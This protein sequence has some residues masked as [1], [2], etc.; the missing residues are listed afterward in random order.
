MTTIINPPTT[1]PQQMTTIIN[2]PTTLPQQMT[3][4]INA[5]T[6]IPQQMTTIINIPTTIPQ[7]M[8]TI[9]NAPTTI[10]QQMTT[11]INIPTTIPQKMTTIINAPTTIPQQMTT[12]INAPTTIPIVNIPTTIPQQMTTIIN[13]PTTIPKQM[14]TIVN[15]PTTIPQPQQMTTYIYTPTTI[16]KQMTTIINIPT[17]I[18]KNIQTTIPET[19]IINVPPTTKP[20]TPT[21]SKPTTTAPTTI[22]PPVKEPTTIPLNIMTIVPQQTNYNICTYNVYLN[23]NC[24]FDN[25]DNFGILSKLKD[26]MLRTYPYNG[27]NVE[28]NAL[29][30]YAFQITNSLNQLVS[31]D[32]DFSNIDLGDCERVL[33]EAYG[34][35]PSMS[36][37]FFK[38]ENIASSGVDRDIQYEVY[39]PITYEKLNLSICE[40]TK[41]KITIPLEISEDVLALI[42]NVLDQGYNPFDLNDRFYRE[43]CTPY[44]SENG[45][46]VLLDARE[47]YVYST[48]AEE[49]T[50]PSGCEMSS[51]SL[52]S[53]YITC[54]CN[55]DDELVALDLNHV[56]AAN[57]MNSFLSTL[58]HSNYKVMI[59]YNLVFNFKIFCHN[60]GS[61]LTLILFVIYVLFMICYCCKE[62]NPIKVSISKLLFEEQKKDSDN[63]IK[64]YIFL[65]KSE[66]SKRGDKSTKSKKK[67]QAKSTKDYNPPKKTK[68][69]R[70]HNA[71]KNLHDLSFEKKKGD[72]KLVDIMKKKR[73]SIKNRPQKDEES[74]KS[75]KVRKRKSIVDYQAEAEMVLKTR[76]NLLQ[77]QQ[78]QGR[79]TDNYNDIMQS[80]KSLNPKSEK[81]KKN[82]K[83]EEEDE[84][85]KEF[86]NFEL[87]N[88]SYDEAS[89]HDRRTCLR[90]YL[91]VLLREHYVLF[92][93]CSRNDYN[94]FYVKIERFFIIVCTEMTMNGMFF[95]HETMYKKKTGQSLTLGQKIPQFVFTLIA[96]HF[97]EVILCWLGMTDIYYYE[98]K[99]LPKIQKNDERIFKILDKMKRRLT[100]FYIFTFFVF[101]FHW[102]FISAFCAVY[103]NTQVIFLRD[104]GIS[105]LTSLIDPF[106]IYG[107]TCILR[108]ISLCMC[109]RKKLCCLYKLSDIIPIF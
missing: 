14:S 95:V 48:I 49:A 41:V 100:G 35:D 12:I 38:S 4:I 17:T 15:A 61:I 51:Y 83:K 28:I 80:A 58:K 108:A 20:T 18:V 109:C 67:K 73:H 68:T 44:N 101:L 64:P 91:S 56:S 40:D 79:V 99:A 105:I 43:I 32:N 94:L 76:D 66:K 71:T 88:M 77:L 86:D 96:S 87:N 62:I 30:G 93:F 13:L 104:S 29:A 84:K 89:E 102:Y 82:K 74:V 24:S 54:E 21:T 55:A 22:P 65:A 2:V 46:D 3:T 1:I 31:N 97:I 37:I 42:Q 52:D 92:T 16:P 75:D 103:Q 33:K 60:Y 36:L 90:T 10:P 57:V 34:I 25:L 72:I 50:C 69:K 107:I 26:E 78:N 27:R 47:E 39:N 70:T 106:I 63:I 98:I 8:T 45:T 11:I 9:I 59:C 19:T 6:T 85:N 5:P 53:K 81:N 23:Y 7:Q